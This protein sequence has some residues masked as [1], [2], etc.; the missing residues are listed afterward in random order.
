MIPPCSSDRN[1]TVRF[2]SSE[3]GTRHFNPCSASD[4]HRPSDPTP[5]VQI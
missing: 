3:W 1:I 2:Q 5:R 4:T